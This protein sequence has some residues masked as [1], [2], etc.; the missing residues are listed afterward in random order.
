MKHAILTCLYVSS[1]IV[2]LCFLLLPIVAIFAHTTPGNLLDQLSNPV[3]TDALIVSF[4][5]SAIAQAMIVLFG[6]PTAY[7]VATHR[8]RGRNALIEFPSHAAAVDCWHSPDYQA[9]MKIREPVSSADVVI[10]EGYDGPQPAD[11]RTR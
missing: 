7:L 8:F 4:K 3:V 10:V 6:T 9:A 5:T 1:T 11:P 2:A